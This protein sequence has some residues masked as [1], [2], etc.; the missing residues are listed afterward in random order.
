VRQG[1]RWVRQAG[2]DREFD[3]LRQRVQANPDA[4]MRRLLD[5]AIGDRPFRWSAGRV[6]VDATGLVR[7]ILAPLG[8][9]IAHWRSGHKGTHIPHALYASRTPPQWRPFT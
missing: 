1:I 8:A 7:L 2:L 3:Q 4:G 6:A 5:E 9:R